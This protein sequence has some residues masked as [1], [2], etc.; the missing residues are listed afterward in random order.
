VFIIQS[1]VCKC[2]SERTLGK[3]RFTRQGK[4]PD[5]YNFLDIVLEKQGDEGK[6]VKTLIADGK[7]VHQTSLWATESL[8]A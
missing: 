7:N 8:T 5:V 3:P 2:L 4:L 6:D 1:G